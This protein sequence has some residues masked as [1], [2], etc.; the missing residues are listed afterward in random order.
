MNMLA[1]RWGIDLVMGIVFLLSALTGILKLTILLQVT[2]LTEIV[3]PA[4]LISMVHDAAGV[5][6]VIL[7]L[8]HLFLNRDWIRVTSRKMLGRAEN[9]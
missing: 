1:L 7:I 2:G 9:R 5:I 3:L 4:A 6:L 8:V